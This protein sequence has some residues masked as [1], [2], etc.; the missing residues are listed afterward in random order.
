LKTLRIERQK[1]FSERVLFEG[2]VHRLTPA[3]AP[4]LLEMRLRDDFEFGHRI[5][6]ALSRS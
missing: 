6:G 3:R 5:G 2:S 4:A 1:Y